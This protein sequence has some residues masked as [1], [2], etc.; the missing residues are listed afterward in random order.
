MSRLW[1]LL[2]YSGWA[3]AA[4]QPKILFEHDATLLNTTIQVI[5]TAGAGD[6]L[7]SQAGLSNLT[8]D[9][10]LRGTRKR[11]REK[12]QV[13]IERLG[14]SVTGTATHDMMVFTARVIREK[15]A[16]KKAYF[17]PKAKTKARERI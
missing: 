3:A 13:E 17:S 15:K 8:A 6:D 11:S 2:V 10:M 5:V 9:L 16:V 1:L 14:A 4:I 7:L 12:F